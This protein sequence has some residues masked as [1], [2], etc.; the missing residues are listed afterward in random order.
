MNYRISVDGGGTF[1][2]GILLDETGKIIVA[3]A[4]TTPQDFT[5]GTI[6]CLSRLAAQAGRSLETL[7]AQTATIVHGTTMATNI[8]ATHTGAK[9]GTITTRGYR[10]RLSFLHV[11]KAE[12]GGDV[13]QGQA[14]LFDFRR[15][16]PKPLNPRYL[17]REVLERV[18][19]KGNVVIPLDEDDVLRAIAHL[20]RHG[21]ESIAVLLLFSQV[22]PAHEHR[23]GEILK[24]EFPEAHVSLSSDILPMWGEVGRWSTTAFN[25]YIA[26][27]VVVYV[28]SL[29]RRLKQHGFAGELVFMQNNGGVATSEVV[30]DNPATILLSGPAAGPAMG[31]ALTRQ[32]GVENVVSVD[33]GG[34]SFDIAVVPEGRVN[35][36][37]HKVIDGKKF[38]LPSVDVSAIGAGG[39]SIAWVDRQSGRLDVGPQSAG[40][41]PGPACYGA[42]GTEPTVTDANVLLG[43]IDPDY[44]LGGETKLRRDLAEQAI[45]EKIARPLALTVE[46]AAASIYD[47]INAK[48]AGAIRL[49]FTR[50][51][52]DPRDFVLCCAGGA[53]PAH[54]VRLAQE[55]GIT[56]LLV[57]KMAPVYCAFGML[58]ADLQHNYTRPY[59]AQSGLA[60]LERINQYYEE[61]ERQAVETLRREGAAD[62]DITISKTMDMRYYGQTRELAADVPPGP[63]TV[64][65][66]AVT[67]K[68]FHDVHR[69]V[70]GY[71]DEGYP[72]EVA[73]LHLAGIARVNPPQPRP[74]GRGDG[75]LLPA[76]KASRRVYFGELRGFVDTDVFDGARLTAGCALEGPC[77]V[78][79]KM[80]T[81]VIPPQVNMHVDPFGNLTTLKEG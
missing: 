67:Q 2:D 80:T 58:Y 26:P 47:V 78:E 41:S 42:G 44:F 13:K 81:I 37:Q 57:P 17:Q 51:G 77:I 34:T 23:V 25:A 1:T 60:D 63:V 3:K 19:F 50:R 74:M 9:L 22:N 31:L 32:H 66:F 48:M 30:A 8:I 24:E 21:V 27:R 71:A 49:A 18:D 36:L 12:L 14:D 46:Q 7:L 40:A 52:F 64:D 72:T 20:R 33:M 43:Y 6:D 68:H 62:K 11:S 29:Q 55:I 73:R 10:D 28:D 45:E 53:G 76:K 59:L 38:A 4:H 56:H 75:N 79:E 65:A 15:E 5:L 39:G 70:I 61:M 35:V 54:G 16:Y 69:T